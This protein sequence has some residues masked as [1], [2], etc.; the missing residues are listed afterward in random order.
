MNSTINE[1]I[2]TLNHLTEILK[3]GEYGFQAAAKDVKA[4][5]LAVIFERY[6]TQRAQFASTLQAHV[7]N[8]GAKVEQTG[9]LV[10]D[11]RRGWMNLKAALATNESHAVLVETERGEGDAVA[12]Y[13]SAVKD[14]NIDQPTRVLLNS[15]YVEIKAAHDNVRTLRDSSKYAKVA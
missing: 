9:T 8:L 6:A 15:Q 7:N 1:T 13:E 11:L 14:R 2:D 4:P 12:A 5:E 3:D 10:G